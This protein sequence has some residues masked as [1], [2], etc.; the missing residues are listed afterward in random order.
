MFQ[1]CPEK[2]VFNKEKGYCDYP[3]SCSGG[4]PPAEPSPT[5]AQPTQP[6]A[7]SQASP[8]NI[9]CAG[10][11]TGYYANGCSS[12]FVYCSEGVATQMKC[13]ESLV[14]NEKKG[15]CDYPESCSSTAPPATAQPGPTPTPSQPPSLSPPSSAVDCTGRPNGHYSNGCTADFVYCSEGTATK[16]KCPLSLVFNG[17]KGYCDYPESCSSDVP[18]DAVSASANSAPS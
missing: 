7:Q 10:K 16:M 14:F 1:K 5:P 13:P 12:D 11:Q 6:P 3:E 4:V 8:S 2:L 18:P 9:D 17:K 15:Y